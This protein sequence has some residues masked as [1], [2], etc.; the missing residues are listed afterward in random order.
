MIDTLK[1]P[2]ALLALAILS[3]TYFSHDSTFDFNNGSQVLKLSHALNGL[4]SASSPQPATNNLVFTILRVIPYSLNISSSTHV[5][6]SILLLTAT[7]ANSEIVAQ[8]DILVLYPSNLPPHLYSTST[9]SSPHLTSP[10]LKRLK[11]KLEVLGLAHI[12]TVG[13]YVPQTL[14]LPDCPQSPQPSY[15]HGE[16][17]STSAWTQAHRKFSKHATGLRVV[18]HKGHHLPT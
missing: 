18:S 5:V 2:K 12:L 14:E 17:R 4:W 3:C 10:L 15:H 11:N 7:A 6:L 1:A 8:F 9:P 13:H 16:R